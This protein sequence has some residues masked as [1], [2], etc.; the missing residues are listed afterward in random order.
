M[1]SDVV[2]EIEIVCYNG[3]WYRRGLD[4]EGKECWEE[5]EEGEYG[6]ELEK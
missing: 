2:V 3:I 1:M 4:W 6:D 5:C